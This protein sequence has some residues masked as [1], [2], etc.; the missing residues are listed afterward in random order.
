[1]IVFR[2]APSRECVNSKQIQPKVGRLLGRS[3]LRASASSQL[4][5]RIIVLKLEFELELEL[6][7]ELEHKLKLKLK[8]ERLSSDRWRRPTAAPGQPVINRPLATLIERAVEL[9]AA[10]FDPLSRARPV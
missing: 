9:V 3:R 8:L 6:G 7:V 4:I 1:M 2:L 5:N 10:G